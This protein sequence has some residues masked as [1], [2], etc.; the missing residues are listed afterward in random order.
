MNRYFIYLAYNGKNYSGWQI[1]PNGRTIQQCLE[2][3]LATLSRNP[4]NITGA[5][6]TDARAHARLMVAPL[7]P[8]ASPPPLVLLPAHL[9]RLLPNLTR[10]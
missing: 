5:G 2:E 1:Q 10:P 3:A 6:R 8:G 9:H 7:D 4:V